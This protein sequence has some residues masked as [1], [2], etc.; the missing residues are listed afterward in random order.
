MARL[1]YILIVHVVQIMSNF[2][3]LEVVRRYRDAQL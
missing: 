1:A 2:H 3:P